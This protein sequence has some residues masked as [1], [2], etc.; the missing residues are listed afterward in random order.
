MK[1]VIV[2]IA[3]VIMCFNSFEAMGAEIMESMG[4]IIY[5]SP[6]GDDENEGTEGFPL[7]TLKKARDKAREM[8]GNVK[9]VLRGGEYILED[10]LVLDFRDSNVKWVGYDGEN[11]VITSKKF[12][13]GWTMHDEGKNIYKAQL[14]KGFNTRQVYFNGEKAKRSRSIS[15]NGG[16]SNLDRTC[17]LGNR[18]RENLEFYFYRNEVDDWN[19]FEDVE[20]HLLTAWTDN[21]L[22]LKKYDENRNFKEVTVDNGG[23]EGVVAAAAVKIQDTEAERIFYRAHP[24]I[25]GDQY[26]YKSRSWYYF[27]NAYEFIDEDT[28]WYFDR[29]S[30]VLYFKAPKGTD[31]TNADVS[32]PALET[33]VSIEGSKKNLVK[34]VSFENIIFECTTWTRP[35]DEGVVGAQA[36]QYTLTTNL[37]NQTTVYHPVSGFYAVYA[38]SLK[39][40]GCTF[41]KMGAVGLDLYYGVKNSSVTNCHIYDVAASGISVAKF[42]QDEKTEYHN[43]YNPSD[44][45]EI[46]KN[47]DIINNTVHNIGTEYEGAVGIIAGYPENI[48]IAHNEIYNTPYSG[49]SVGFG[50]TSAENAMRNNM[51][52]ANRIYNTGLVLCDAGAIYT[53]SKQPD[54]LCARNYISNIKAQSWF[55]YGYGAMY[56]DEQ[57]EHYV[58][59]ENLLTDLGSDVWGGGI[60]FNR[61]QGKNRTVNNYIG[62]DITENEAARSVA[63]NAGVIEGADCTLLA[64][65]AEMYL[66]EMLHPSSIVSDN[67]FFV[68]DYDVHT[69]RCIFSFSLRANERSDGFIGLAGADI[70][71]SY[72]NSFPVV[73][74][75][76][77]EGWFDARNGDVFEY[78]NEVLYDVSKDY[79]IRIEADVNEKIYSVYVTDDSGMTKLVAE[80]FKFR[81]DAPNVSDLSRLCVRGGHGVAGGL[82]QIAGISIQND[83]KAEIINIT[84]NNEGIS[85]EIVGYD[86]EKCIVFCCFYSEDGSLVYSGMTNVELKQLEMIPVFM[87]MEKD[88]DFCKVFIWNEKNMHP[89]SVYKKNKSY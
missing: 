1:K 24:N 33:L 47:I 55:D 85:F 58:I 40:D 43:A 34:N 81:S 87:Q 65:E 57:T 21:V 69:N 66:E 45:S 17:E 27:E 28:E 30:A 60:N 79:F 26:A 4:E 46:T 39:V 80:N 51:I 54:S 31:M 63:E 22:R 62:V 71:P 19:N 13:T 11:A 10:T 6:Y 29:H 75:I 52:F 64:K 41:R 20:I 23:S 16:Y 50:W 74:R 56:F 73:L 38:D 88:Y 8:D 68:Y 7:R 53:L 14:E 82:F 61:S 86:D 78:K 89:V 84:E 44:K 49:I 59:T 18:M 42:V 37:Q 77:P 12:V 9:I 35:S 70:T 83:T 72:W 5:I 32:V 3:C 15:Y 2:F 36:C 48:V 76:R 67:S 25:A